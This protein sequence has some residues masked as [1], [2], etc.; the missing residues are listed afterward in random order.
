MKS[1]EKKHETH[2]ELV[3]R[4]QKDVDA[5]LDE[6]S[7]F[8]R[9]KDKEDDDSPKV[10]FDVDFIIKNIHSKKNRVRDMHTRNSAKIEHG[11]IPSTIHQ[12]GPRLYDGTDFMKRKNK[13]SSRF[14]LKGFQF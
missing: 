9:V 4:L 13:R 5:I 10:Q 8:L 7:H 1:H 12:N 2:E 3:A 6:F 14:F 11:H